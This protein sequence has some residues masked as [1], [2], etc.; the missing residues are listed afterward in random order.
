MGSE[1][2]GGMRAILGSLLAVAPA[3]AETEDDPAGITCD[4]QPPLDW[5][6]FGSGFVDL[7]CTSC[8]SVENSEPQRSGAPLGVDFDTYGDVV[9]HVERIE[10]EAIG[11]DPAMP[12]SGGPTSAELALFRE[13]LTCAVWP[14]HDVLESNGQL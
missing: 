2:A 3:C 6:N 13:W 10:H 14:D 1:M 9:E 4:R 12:P 5:H 7:H 8:H 11:A